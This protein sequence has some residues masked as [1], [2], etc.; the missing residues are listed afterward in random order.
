MIVKLIT[1]ISKVEVLMN[2]WDL[3]L[4]NI[5]KEAKKLKD[6]NMLD[7]CSKIALIPN[8][9]KLYV[10]K[11]FIMNCMKL[12]KIGFIQWRIRFPNIISN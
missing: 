3:L 2:S 1:R 4:S 7:I 6:K 5:L 12:Y 10:L 8:E 11:R 9:V